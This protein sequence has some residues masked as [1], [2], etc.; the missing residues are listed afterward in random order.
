MPGIAAAAVE[1]LG[2]YHFDRAG[3]VHSRALRAASAGAFSLDQQ[4]TPPY[5]AQLRG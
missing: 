4:R 5:T 3:A 1:I 2:K